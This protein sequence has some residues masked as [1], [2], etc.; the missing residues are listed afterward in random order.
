[1][2]TNPPLAKE[3]NYDKNGGLKPDEVTPNSHK[4]V[5]WKC[6]HGHEWQ[7]DIGGRN[8]GNGCPE[9]ARRKSAK[10]LK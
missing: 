1:M 9:C 8:R 3:W 4:K 5:W 7:A 6:S 10:T 2:K